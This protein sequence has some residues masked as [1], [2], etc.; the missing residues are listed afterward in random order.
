MQ[1][2]CSCG[3]CRPKALKRAGKSGEEVRR[4]K[5][6]RSEQVRGNKAVKQVKPSEQFRRH[7]HA[8]VNFSFDFVVLGHLIGC[9]PLQCFERVHLSKLFSLSRL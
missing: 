7:V 3:S 2:K 9:G 8:V 1:L 5:Q 4:E 6:D